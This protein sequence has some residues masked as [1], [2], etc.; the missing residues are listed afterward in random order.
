MPVPRSPQPSPRAAAAVDQR[1]PDA[2][3]IALLTAA[4][5][6]DDTLI[7][8]ADQ[9]L[10]IKLAL[11]AYAQDKTAWAEHHRGTARAIE[12]LNDQPE[13]FRTQVEG[14]RSQVRRERATATE[15]QDL[16]DLI[17]DARVVRLTLAPSQLI[18]GGA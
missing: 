8:T 10:L 12:V 3:G 15:A 4:I 2:G 18:G 9:V 1:D 13:R 17:Y 16:A 5:R 7:L 11:E 6:A 14:L